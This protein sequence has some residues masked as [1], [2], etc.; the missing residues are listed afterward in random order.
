MYNLKFWFAQVGLC[1]MRWIM[2]IN[3]KKKNLT[4][5][6]YYFGQE[7]KQKPTDVR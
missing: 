1:K 2:A 4:S 3:R 6:N 7:N 5:D